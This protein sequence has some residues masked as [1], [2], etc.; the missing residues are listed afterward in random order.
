MRRL[1]KVLH[2][3]SSR[4]LILK[5]KDGET[6]VGWKV[7]DSKLREVGRVYEMFGPVA[8]PYVSVKPTISDPS[9]LV[10]KVLYIADGSN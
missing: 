9:S 7:L 6:T 2:L 1:G 5:T 10:G 3:S 8:S 4:S